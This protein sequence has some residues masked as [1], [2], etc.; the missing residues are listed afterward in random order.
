MWECSDLFEYVPTLHKAGRMHFM[1]QYQGK[2]RYHRLPI[3]LIFCMLN[4]Q[5][6]PY[7]TT[8]FYFLLSNSLVCKPLAPNWCDL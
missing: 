1:S 2:V 3:Y 4:D 5:L 6:N 8:Y 7:E